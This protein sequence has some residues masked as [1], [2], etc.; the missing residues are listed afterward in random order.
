MVQIKRFF[1]KIGNKIHKKGNSSQSSKK[2]TSNN[3]ESPKY[4]PV[5]IPT[6][7]I[8]NSATKVSTQYQS[9]VQ[10][11]SNLR[12]NL[13]SIIKGIQENRILEVFDKFY[14]QD[15]V[16]YEKGDST[17]RVGFAENRK[18]E[19]GF[20]SNA[21]VHEAKVLKI[22]VDADN[23]AY[24]MYMDFTYGGNRIQ[25]TQWAFQQ[26]KDNKVIIIFKNL[27][28]SK[29][30]T[31]HINDHPDHFDKF[32]HID[33]IK[34]SLSSLKLDDI[35]DTTTTT[36]TTTTTATNNNISNDTASN[37]TNNCNNSNK[38]ISQINIKLKSIWES[39]RLSTSLYQSL[40]TTENDIKQ[41]F[42]QLHQYL[43]IEEH[44]LQKP[45]SDDKHK[46]TNKIENYITNLKYLINVINI[47]NKV[48]NNNNGINHDKSNSSKDNDQSVIEDTTSLFSTKTIMESITT[49]S[50]LQS[51]INDNNQTLFNEYNNNNFNIL[52]EHSS[53]ST[54]L[55][56]D[57]IYKY[58]NQFKSTTIT[59]NNDN[60]SLSS[61]KISIKQL[62]FNQLNSII[63]QSIKVDKIE[64][65]LKPTSTTK[66]TTTNNNDNKQT[67][68]FVTHQKRGA[69]LINTSNNYSI[70]E[71]QFDYYF[72]YTDSAIVSIGEYIYIFGGYPNTN[73]KK[74]LKI[75][76]K[77]KSIEHIGDYEG[78]RID[79]CISV[80]YD[81]Q[82][83]IYLVNG[84]VQNRIDRFNILTMKF[85]S[86][87]Q[88][89][90]QYGQQAS[91]MIF[92]GSLYSISYQQNKLFQFDLTN[93][94][95]KDHQIDIIPYSA[96]N[97]K[98]GNF[99]ILDT[100]KKLFLK[101][102]VETK[103]TINLNDI[104]LI[105]ETYRYVKYHRE[106]PTS[107]FIYSFANSNDYNFKYSIESNQWEPFFRN[108]SPN[109]RWM[110]GST[111]ITL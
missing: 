75:S 16:M 25:K 59:D 87:H 90:G 3:L 24:E 11:N 71:L 58:N 82:D 38:F 15:I 50:S 43:I 18:V 40:T 69:T 73:Q 107:S 17:N 53:D 32:E 54:S 4:N 92:K 23:T 81:G 95:I 21:T 27:M 28:C 42:E 26:W 65:T 109:A 80:C 49:N 44:K 1:S 74:W 88:L 91:S 78:I 106:S 103:Q 5:S 46:I 108:I 60:S 61:Y 2:Q 31:S 84:S 104:P 55:L 52:K 19:E 33:D 85:E 41:H 86:Y 66:T 102:N 7:T 37:N 64:S 39:L 51:F 99:F 10:S 30:I 76:I 79:S 97:D 100:T 111:S 48:N 70:E 98:N 13:E 68:I 101:Y 57:I 93:R 34:N 12:L 14:H 36:T 9:Q 94:M 89:P 6:T 67:Y 20:S 83:Y 72:N 62:D 63:E 110:C 56:L 77:S 96:C 47:F 35:I 8:T 29:C 105:Y 22:I 45:I